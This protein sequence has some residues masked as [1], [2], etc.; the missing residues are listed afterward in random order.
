MPRK[1]PDKRVL[2]S[3][4]PLRGS[5][6][7]LVALWNALNN[8]KMN[9]EY[10]VLEVKCLELAHEAMEAGNDMDVRLKGG[11]IAAGLIGKR[12]DLKIKVVERLAKIKASMNVLVGE[13]PKL[14]VEVGE[15]L[16][17]AQAE[18]LRE[19]PGRGDD[20]ASDGDDDPGGSDAAD[21]DGVHDPEPGEGG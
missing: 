20:D 1:S 21:P 15:V 6:Q 9:V 17:R 18:L 12:N 10:E 8:G 13:T 4:A 14:G 19:G 5:G 2:E 11:Q 3:I 7:A 16:K